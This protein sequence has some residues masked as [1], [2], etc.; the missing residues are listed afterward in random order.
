M[1]GAHSAREGGAGARVGTECDSGE[2]SEVRDEVSSGV[3][4][5]AGVIAHD[6]V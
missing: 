5:V 1:N 2:A 6:A 3:D 4:G